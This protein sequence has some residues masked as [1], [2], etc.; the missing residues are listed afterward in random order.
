[1]TTDSQRYLHS[2]VL[3]HLELIRSTIHKMS[4]PKT[5]KAVQQKEKGKP[6]EMIDVE[7]K[8]PGK[9]QVVVKVLACGG[10]SSLK[11]LDFVIS[12]SHLRAHSL[13]QRRHCQAGNYACVASYPRT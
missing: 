7:M 1:M 4:L 9:R 11:I 6:F 12:D 10:T 13:P 3:T 8:E 5:Y 2:L